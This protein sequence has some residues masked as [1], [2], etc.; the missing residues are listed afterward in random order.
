MA[1]RSS[2]SDRSKPVAAER[3]KTASTTG[4]RARTYPANKWLVFVIV[5]AGVFMST[6][7]ASIVNIALPTIMADLQVP[8]MVI[9]WVPMIYLL[10][11][12]SLL[13]TCGRLSDIRGRRQVYGSGF[14]VFSIGSLLC[15]IA[16]GAPLLIASRALQ[17]M[18]AF[19]RAMLTGAAIAGLGVV[20]SYLR[21][22]D[23]G[24][25]GLEKT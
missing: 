3:Q 23:S 25:T 22:Q 8:L 11:V 20:V 1:K 13:L 14:V 6:L 4:E 7:D 24:R 17:G 5:A 21:G 12:S 19:Q 10:T 2:F 16:A 9:E 15:A 18:G